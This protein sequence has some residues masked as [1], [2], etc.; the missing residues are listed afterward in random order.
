[1]TKLNR[2]N[3]NKILGFLRENPNFQRACK[4]AG[5]ARST[6]YRWMEDDASFRDNVRDA[7]EIGQDTMNDYTEAKLVENVQNNIQRA[8]EFYL[9]HNNPKYASN[10]VESE[11]F[12]KRGI[13]RA[14]TMPVGIDQMYYQGELKGIDFAAT[15]LLIKHLSEGGMIDPN[16]YIK[17]AAGTA[18]AYD[19]MIMKSLFKKFP[20]LSKEYEKEDTIESESRL[21]NLEEFKSIAKNFEDYNPTATLEEFLMEI[22]LISDIK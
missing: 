12:D 14:L 11:Y 5:F 1:M 21:E 19:P 18:D 10:R 20:E 17:N 8:I 4:K 15:L 16:D 9:R 6:V 22:S 13:A 2:T 7:Q 3:R